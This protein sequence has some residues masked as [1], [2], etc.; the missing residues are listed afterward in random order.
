MR[1]ENLTWKNDLYT[2]LE[3]VLALVAVHDT[4]S[5]WLLHLFDCSNLSS[6]FSLLFF[7]KMIRLS[8]GRVF[9]GKVLGDSTVG[10]TI[11]SAH[12]EYVRSPIFIFS[13]LVIPVAHAYTNTYCS[14]AGPSCCPKAWNTTFVCLRLVFFPWTLLTFILQLK[15]LEVPPAVGGKLSLDENE[16]QSSLPRHRLVCL[17]LH[18]PAIPQLPLFPSWYFFFF[19]TVLFSVHITICSSSPLM[20]LLKLLSLSKVNWLLGEKKKCLEK[21]PDW[22]AWLSISIWIEERQLTM[23]EEEEVLRETSVRHLCFRCFLPILTHFSADPRG[24]SK[25]TFLIR[26]AVTSLYMQDLVPQSV[27]SFSAGSAFL[28]A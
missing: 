9:R 13:L 4:F 5:D 22:A 10:D 12:T 25:Q 14:M 20:W 11:A 7:C 1:H 24:Y 2:P 19:F 15:V 17:Y 28:W 3:W 18:Y 8:Y 26:T 23:S 6:P 27:L 21:L 16:L